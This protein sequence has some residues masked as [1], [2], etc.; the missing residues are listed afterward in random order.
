MRN[1]VALDALGIDTKNDRRR[2]ARQIINVP[3]EV[4][5]FGAD[6]KFFAEVTVTTNISE[7]G[8]SFQLKQRLERG[9]IVAIKLTG[10]G[11]PTAPKEHLFLYQVVHATSDERGWAIGTAKLQEAS[12]WAA[13]TSVVKEKIR[14]AS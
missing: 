11:S 10:E 12:V 4:T 9:G 6:G 3:I 14:R 2:E 13:I 5:G 7:R 1:S 8:C